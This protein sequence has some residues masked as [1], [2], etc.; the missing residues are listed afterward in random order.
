VMLGASA[1]DGADLVG[2]TL[3]LQGATATAEVFRS[4]HPAR[5]DALALTAEDPLSQT[6][7]RMGLTGSVAA[8]IQI[9]G[10]LWGAV[11]IAASE[12]HIAAGAELRL[13]RFA[14]LASLAITNLENLEALEHRAATDPLTGI[15]N[16]RTFHD[17]LHVEVERARRYGRDL[18]V[19][20]LDL[21][22]FKSINDTHGH[23]TGDRILVQVAQRLT[24]EARVGELVAR[25]GGEEFAW[26]IPESGQ[27]DAYAAA[28]RVRRAIESTPLAD[29]CAVTLSAGVGSTEHAR[30]AQQLMR[31]A[32]RALYRAKEHGRNNT[33]VYSD[34]THAVT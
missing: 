16:H 21:D 28:E 32:D 18:S 9:G 15:A 20:L 6:V 11:G 33:C 24:D 25:L 14:R 26:V 17:R 3:D 13:E 8:P 23:Q 27:H 10:A 30:D 19:V 7:Q 12:Q 29:I 34:D 1:S 4:G 2:T 5:V 22:H 31:N